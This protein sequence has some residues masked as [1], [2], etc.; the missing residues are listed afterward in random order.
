[1]AA[2][3]GFKY[4]GGIVGNF[5]EQTFDE[6]LLICQEKLGHIHP[7]SKEAKENGLAYYWTGKECSKG[8]ISYRLMSNRSCCACSLGRA[9]KRHQ[10]SSKKVLRSTQWVAIDEA[11]SAAKKLSDADLE[12]QRMVKKKL[13]DIEFNKLLK[14]IEEEYSC[15]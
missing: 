12:H 6:F 4:I 5:I 15:D 3:R 7:S 10:K 8:H 1:M 13:A 9:K 11:A 2:L 14:E